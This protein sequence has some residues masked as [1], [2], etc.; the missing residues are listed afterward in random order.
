[1]SLVRRL[2]LYDTSMPLAMFFSGGQ[3]VH[4]SPDFVYWS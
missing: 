3:T 2:A 1:M 4:Y